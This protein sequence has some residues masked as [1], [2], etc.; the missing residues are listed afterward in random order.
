MKSQRKEEIASLVKSLVFLLFLKVRTQMSLSKIKDDA[1]VTSHFISNSSYSPAT[2]SIEPV[3]HRDEHVCLLFRKPRLETILKLFWV[4][5][6]NQIS[7]F[8]SQRLIG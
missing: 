4:C 3:H 7:T 5:Y 1:I 2:L 8:I 6:S